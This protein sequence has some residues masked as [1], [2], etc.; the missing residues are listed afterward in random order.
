[1]GNLSGIGGNC[2]GWRV[3]D[4]ERVCK[5]CKVALLFVKGYGRIKRHCCDGGGGCMYY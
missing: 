3:E 2:R 4:Y 5:E 1:M